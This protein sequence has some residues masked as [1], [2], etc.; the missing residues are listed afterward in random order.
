MES[1]LLHDF[2][3]NFFPHKVEN[4]IFTWNV[5]RE[6]RLN[7]CEVR[8]NI[9]TNFETGVGQMGGKGVEGAGA[10]GEGS[11]GPEW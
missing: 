5:A 3:R 7:P 11:R 8:L 10:R 2:F 1:R 6:M 4:I 9:E